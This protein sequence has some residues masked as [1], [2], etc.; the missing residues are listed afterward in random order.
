M[1]FSVVGMEDEYIGRIIELVK[2]SEG[3]DELLK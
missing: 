1:K 3:D 2:D